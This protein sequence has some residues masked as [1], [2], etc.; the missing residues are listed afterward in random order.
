MCSTGSANDGVGLQ[1]NLPGG[2]ISFFTRCNIV[3]M[4]IAPIYAI[5]VLCGQG[6]RRKARVLHSMKE[7][8]LRDEEVC[9]SIINSDEVILERM[10]YGGIGDGVGQ[11]LFRQGASGVVNSNRLAVV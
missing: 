10:E 4:A 7:Q 1:Q 5:L 3:T 11:L 2:K 9:S 8:M 6:H